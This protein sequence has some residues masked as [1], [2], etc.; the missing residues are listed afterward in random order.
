MRLPLNSIFLDLFQMLSENKSKA[1]ADGKGSGRKREMLR[2][3]ISDY[4][5]LY[6]SLLI[7]VV[8]TEGKNKS[9]HTERNQRAATTNT[10]FKVREAKEVLRNEKS[11]SA[12][13]VPLSTEFSS[14][15]SAVRLVLPTPS[16]KPE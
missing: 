4:W 7:R 14:L 6:F 3:L 8:N 2:H 1:K 9:S 15:E 11:F 13:S 10:N 16:P 5:Y 12:L